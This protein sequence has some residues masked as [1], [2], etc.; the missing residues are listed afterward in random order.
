M[1]RPP[2]GITIEQLAVHIRRSGWFTDPALRA[3][4]ERW[5]REAGDTA[6]A[7]RF[8]RWLVARR[9]LTEEQVSQIVTD[10]LDVSPMAPPTAIVPVAQAPLA[11]P[12]LNAVIVAPPAEIN[13]ELVSVSAE[14]KLETR[15]PLAEAD[16]SVELVPLGDL[17]PSPAAAPPPVQVPSTN[18]GLYL[19]LGALGLLAVQVAG[20]VFGWL[21]AALW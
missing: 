4:E 12:V 17:Q 21:L 13:V 5:Q 7:R 10:L 14:P 8:T 19:C 18:V 2:P 16:I 15:V 11:A 3:L 6:D 9:Y 20:W 1:K